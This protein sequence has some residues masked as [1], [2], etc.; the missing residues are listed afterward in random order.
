MRE[1]ETAQNSPA[2]A[3]N[4]K[5]A[6]PDYAGV[7][8]E[9]NLYL[10]H[11]CKDILYLQGRIFSALGVSYAFEPQ[12]ATLIKFFGACSCINCFWG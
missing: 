10:R 4:P 2:V 8:A 6:V 7:H 11:L 1:I 12:S 3:I 5:S 9:K